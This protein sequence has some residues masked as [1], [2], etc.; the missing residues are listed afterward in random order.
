M[1]LIE[2][3]HQQ[4][5]LSTIGVV[6]ISDSMNCV[7]ELVEKKPKR[8]DPCPCN[9]GKKYK[10]CHS[11][12]Q[13]DPDE[14]FQVAVSDIPIDFHFE[15]IDGGRTLVR[16]PGVTPDDFRLRVHI[17]GVASATEEVHKLFEPITRLVPSDRPILATRLG[18]L[19]HKLYGVKYHMENFSRNE[20]S[21]VSKMKAQSH[22]AN[23]VDTL[24]EE[25]IILY[26][27]EGF[28]FQVKSTLDVLTQVI[29]VVF[30]LGD[31]HSYA[32]GGEKL[33]KTLIQNS[34]TTLKPTALELVVVIRKYQQWVEDIVD[35]RDEITH[36]S[37]LEG[38]SCFIVHA[39][40]GGGLVKISYPAMPNGKRARKYIENTW[41]TLVELLSG[42]MAVLAKAIC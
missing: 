17:R 14:Y 24:I 27:L 19:R 26:E 40:I 16:S 37:D 3:Y 10:N 7:I 28:L 20:D 1:P 23:G 30:K 6:L 18:K 2:D 29:S 8:N 25:P 42:M 34:P 31:F 21:E 32:D 5:Y 22:T 15:S 35:M 41:N 4:L 12:R 39:Y 38:F 13:F 33:I 9:S 11:P 36:Y